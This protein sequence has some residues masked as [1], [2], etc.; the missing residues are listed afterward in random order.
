MLPHAGGICKSMEEVPMGVYRKQGAWWID[1]YEGRR[2]RRKKTL[3]V[4]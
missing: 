4:Q 1:R 2:R 3:P